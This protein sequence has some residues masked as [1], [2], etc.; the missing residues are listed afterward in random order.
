MADAVHLR[1]VV[2]L[3][4]RYP[5]L[6]GADLDVAPGEVVLLRGGN[7]AG[8]TS[9]LR[10]CAGLL[11]AA[12]GEVEVL[13]LDLRRDPREVRRRVGLLGHSTHLYDDLSVADNVR[14]AVRAAGGSRAAA[15]SALERFGLG[16][17]LG[18]LRAAHLSAGQRR[19]AA[20]AAEGRALVDSMI[21]TAVAGGATVV[22]A[23]HE[24]AAVA[25]LPVRAVT[26]AGGRV[27]EV[28]LAA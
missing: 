4:G 6:A 20:L 18:G 28:A 5:A 15:D 27:G 24:D 23:S 3:V 22:L 14:F 12:T 21:G 25:D 2:A 19:R 9:L 26:L 17:R 11:R 8:K 7:G 13:G 10:V 1:S 16:G